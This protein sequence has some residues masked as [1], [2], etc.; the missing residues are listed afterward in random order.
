MSVAPTH[1]LQATAGRAARSDTAVWL[2]RA[3]LAG[4]GLLYVAIGLVALRIA[5]GGAATSADKQ[6]ALLAI[7]Q[8]PGGRALLIATAVGLVAYALWCAAKAVI[9]RKD[10]AAATW[11]KRAGYLG[12]AVI[13]GSAFASAI[14]ILTAQPQSNSSAEQ[15]GWTATVMG[16]PGGRLLVGA[17]GV[18][19]FA[20][21]GW[22]IYRAATRGFEHHLDTGA[23]SER[24]RSVVRAAA[25]G[26]L[27][28]RAVA[29]AAV[30]W[31]VVRAAVQFDPTEPIGLDA[32]LRALQQEG[33]GPVVI[34]IVGIGLGLFGLFSFAEARYRQLPE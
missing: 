31:F 5:T 9:A 20:A 29:F 21:A 4:R 27:I 15:H 1:Q 30:G 12:R 24:T 17:A 23:M 25:Y 7:V 28:G 19:L 34:T 14:S 33:Y 3:G 6:G 11:A 26:G 32:S 16:W 18:A 22:N 2:G 8:R 10:S 13:Y